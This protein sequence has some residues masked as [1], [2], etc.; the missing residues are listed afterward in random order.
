MDLYHH[1]N[2]LFTKW[3]VDNELLEEAFTVMDVGCQGGPH[4]R[5]NHVVSAEVRFDVKTNPSLGFP[6]RGLSSQRWRSTWDLD[7]PLSNST[8]S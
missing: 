6:L 4:P 1:T 8:D 3:I 5:R 2:P 7:H